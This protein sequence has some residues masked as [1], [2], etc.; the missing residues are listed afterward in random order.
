[1]YD[2]LISVE[3]QFA[4]LCYFVAVTFY[5]L[6]EPECPERTTDFWLE[7]IHLQQLQLIITVLRYDEMN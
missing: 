1:M 5:W 4:L 3:R 2:R 7:N 6:G